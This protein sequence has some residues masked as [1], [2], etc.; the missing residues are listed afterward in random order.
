MPINHITE[1]SANESQPQPLLL[2]I[3]AAAKR[4]SV[5]PVTIRMILPEQG[6]M[7]VPQG[8]KM[9]KFS[10]LSFPKLRNSTKA[11]S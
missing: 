11:S 6:E 1:Q 8:H 2:D 10:S 3:N 9:R 4:L 7:K 5:A